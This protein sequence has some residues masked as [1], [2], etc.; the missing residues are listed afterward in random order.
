MSMEHIKNSRYLDYFLK[1]TEPIIQA[2]LRD[3]VC[4]K[5]V[6]KIEEEE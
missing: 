4:L 2:L 6:N 3:R 5:Y 1:L